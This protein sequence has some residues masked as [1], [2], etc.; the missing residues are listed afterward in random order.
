MREDSEVWLLPQHQTFIQPFSIFPIS[1]VTLL[2]RHNKRLTKMNW[3]GGQRAGASKTI[4]GPAHRQKQYFARVRAANEAAAYSAASEASSPNYHDEHDP[5]S[6]RRK[7]HKPVPEFDILRDQPAKTSEPLRYPAD[8]FDFDDFEPKKTT[9]GPKARKRRLLEQGDWVG[10][11]KAQEVNEREQELAGKDNTFVEKKVR[12]AKSPSKAPSRALSRFQ[13]LS[14]APTRRSSRQQAQSQPQPSQREFQ[15]PAPTVVTAASRDY[16][17]QQWRPLSQGGYI[18]IGRTTLPS[19]PQV[20]ICSDRSFAKCS[21]NPEGTSQDSMLLDYEETGSKIPLEEIL[22]D[23]Y[24]CDGLDYDSDGKFDPLDWRCIKN[25]NEVPSRFRIRLAKFNRESAA[26]QAALLSSP[27]PGS[28]KSS[29]SAATKGGSEI[30]AFKRNPSS[31][32]SARNMLMNGNL[33]LGKLGTPVGHEFTPSS[34]TRINLRMVRRNESSTPDSPRHD[35]EITLN[36]DANPLE[37]QWRDFL[38]VGD[39]TETSLVSITEREQEGCVT[40][41]SEVDHSDSEVELLNSNPILSSSPPP[42]KNYLPPNSPAKKRNENTAWHSFTG[43]VRSSPRSPTPPSPKLPELPFTASQDRAW[44]GFVFA[45]KVPSDEEIDKVI[46][47]E[48][49]LKSKEQKMVV[50][51]EV[52][53]ISGRA[54]AG[55]LMAITTEEQEE[56]EEE[57]HVQTHKDERLDWMY[58]NLGRS[59]VSEV[60]GSVVAVAGTEVGDRERKEE[61]DVNT[62]VG[63]VGAG[64]NGGLAGMKLWKPPK[65]F[66]GKRRCTL[67]D[68]DE[69]IEDIEDW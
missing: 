58:S 36:N 67:V 41:T 57:R 9:L 6:S 47:E 63:T 38:D 4:I 35:T 52:S 8:V 59:E 14:Q 2:F 18:R 40:N 23:P 51:S 17:I 11:G 68:E 31:P 24:N 49:G 55:S 45:Y 19:P 65:R 3:T 46:A 54:E 26:E 10:V 22:P 42:I 53:M 27:A 28:L 66:E 16:G 7:R 44:H 37:D 15:P 29:S 33:V 56:E 48:S 21:K 62:V 12:A 5:M 69:A 20:I 34:P 39:D 1:I 64:V 30:F 61:D 43:P 60:G 13:A 50:T 25:Y 32:P